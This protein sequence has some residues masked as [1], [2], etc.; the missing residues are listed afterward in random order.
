MAMR[1]LVVLAAALSLVVG[2]PAVALA[3]ATETVTI[4]AE[5]MYCVNC[6]ARVESALAGLDGV[7]DVTADNES[8]TAKVTYDPAKVTP[9]D[10]VATIDNETAYVGGMPGEAADSGSDDGGAASQTSEGDSSSSGGDDAASSADDGTQTAQF[11]SGESGASSQQGAGV[12]PGGGLIAAVG[13]VLLLALAGGA[14]A[15]ARR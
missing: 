11:T 1:R 6:E 14:W 5:G 15:V 2:L 4:K 12:L 9:E 13:A 3:A 10:M 8:E 7:K